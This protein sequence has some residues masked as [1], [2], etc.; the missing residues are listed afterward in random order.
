M[1]GPSLHDTRRV[2][3][4]INTGSYPDTIGRQLQ[5]LAGKPPSTARGGT[6]MPT[7]RTPP[8]ATG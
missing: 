2:R 8:A 6:T 7:S 4:V 5:L 1:S 3:R